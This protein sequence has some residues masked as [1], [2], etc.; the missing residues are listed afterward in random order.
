MYIHN[1][2]CYLLEQISCLEKFQLK[3]NFKENNS[4]TP[5]LIIINRNRHDKSAL[6]VNSEFS[7][8]PIQI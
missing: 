4:I 3:N 1:T 6:K 7:K 8:D 2:V 5:S